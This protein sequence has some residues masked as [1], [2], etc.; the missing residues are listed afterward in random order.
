LRKHSLT[1][2][3]IVGKGNH[4][5]NH[6]QKIKP[7]VERVCQEQGLQYHT[8][9][10][11][12]RMYV[13]L[14]GGNAPPPSQYQSGPSQNYSQEQYGKPHYET[15][16]P[17]GGGASYGAWSNQQHGGAQ[18]QYGGQQQHQQQNYGGQQQQGGAQQE[19]DYEAEIKKNLPAILRLFKRNCCVVM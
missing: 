8:E 13:D 12:G 9:Q 18:Q 16:Y 7:M 17:M 10:N 5:V 2:S 11:E 3:S 1:I 6:I 14:T 4:S 19:F 15:A